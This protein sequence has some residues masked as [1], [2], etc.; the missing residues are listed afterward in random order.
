MIFLCRIKSILDD[1]D[2]EICEFL[3][4]GNSFN[5]CLNR[6]TSDYK[7]NDP[8]M[9]EKLLEI[10]IKVLDDVDIILDHDQYSYFND[11]Y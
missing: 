1:K 2:E 5:E 7:E 10:K 11:M 9:S 6:I 4:S 3:T 8:N